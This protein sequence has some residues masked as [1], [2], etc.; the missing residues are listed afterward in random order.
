ML[1]PD[2]HLIPLGF[3]VGVYG[4]II[5]S[6][7]GFLLVPMLLFL[8]PTT[9]PATITAMSL[10]VVFFNA[11]SG[12]I[13]LARQGWTDY[14]LGAI[15]ALAT[16][17]GAVLGALTVQFVPRPLFAGLFGF[18]LLALAVVVILRPQPK[19]VGS[20]P[21]RPGMLSRV[22]VDAAGTRF[23]YHLSLWQGVVLSLGVGFFSSLLGIG[24]GVIHV[25]AMVFILDLPPHIAA[26]TSQFILTFT[27]LTGSVVHLLAGELAFGAGLRR[28]LLLAA[29]VVPGAFVGAQLA[30]RLHGTAITR[31]L[32][33]AL[34]IVGARLLLDALGR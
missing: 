22:V 11:A 20:R 21:P 31:L 7:G 29:G 33:V 13:A 18:L 9:Q 28:A 32:G 15:F 26:A 24:G 8:Y 2:W 34:A 10:L 6:G 3:L 1:V 27:A 4:T 25:P 16:V 19:A 17:P 5:G 14:R 30:R 23:E 12:S